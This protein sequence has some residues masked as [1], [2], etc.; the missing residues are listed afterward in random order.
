MHFSKISTWSSFRSKQLQENQA[1]AW[2]C[3]NQGKKLATTG[4][5]S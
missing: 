3:I 5:L 4:N 1:A 2:F